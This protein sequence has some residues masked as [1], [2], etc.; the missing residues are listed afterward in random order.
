M[1][2]LMP[3]RY[4]TDHSVTDA[5]ALAENIGMPHHTIAIK[6]IYNQYT[7]S[8]RPVFG[9]LPFDVTEEN[10]QARIRGMLV[11][12]LSNKLGL[13]CPQHLQQKRS[14][15]R[16]WHPLRRPLRLAQ[17]HRGPLQNRRLC[18][19]P[20]HQPR[21]GNH[22]APH[23][24]KSPLSRTASGAKRPGHLAG[25]CPTRRHPETP[26]RGQPL[27][28]S[29]YSQRVP[30]RNRPQSHRHG[31]SQRIQ[32]RPMPPQP[33]NQHQG[34]RLRQ[35]LSFLKP[36]RQGTTEKPCTPSGWSLPPPLGGLACRHARANGGGRDRKCRYH[37]H[38][39]HN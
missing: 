6:D 4:S 24:R 33:Q 19:C 13:Y 16:L 39:Q 15:S 1:G 2:I 32:T 31:H 29:H 37:H 30:G 18:P 14:G 10:L 23:H 25:L 27:S 38:V 9:D 28:R 22:P 5:E 8:L 20:P 26:P 17:R 35:A 36:L 21:A 12:A 7:E 11:M 3:S 34:I